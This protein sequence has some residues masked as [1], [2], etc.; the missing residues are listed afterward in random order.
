[1][2]LASALQDD[3]AVVILDERPDGTRSGEAGPGP[4]RRRATRTNL[5]VVARLAVLGRAPADGARHLTY[6][7]SILYTFSKLFQREE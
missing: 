3:P 7:Y 5:V 2:S 1:V 6:A 4:R